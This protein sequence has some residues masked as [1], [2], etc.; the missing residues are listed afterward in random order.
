M[1]IYIYIERYIYIYIY[2]HIIII[3]IIV[4]TV[5]VIMASSGRPASRFCKDDSHKSISINI[6][7]YN[8]L[9]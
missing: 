3:I 6:C 1:H 9:D 2:T 4:I 5:V 8:I 7:F